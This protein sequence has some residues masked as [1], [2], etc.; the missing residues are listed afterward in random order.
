MSESF[1]EYVLEQAWDSRGT[2]SHSTTAL[3]GFHSQKLWGLLFPALE[4]WAPDPVWGL[5]SLLLWGRPPQLKFLSCFL[6]AT[7]WIGAHQFRV[8]SH[9]TSLNEAFSVYRFTGLLFS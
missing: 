6:T 1:C 3:A 8:S 4:P 9:P 5:D 7:P 2:P